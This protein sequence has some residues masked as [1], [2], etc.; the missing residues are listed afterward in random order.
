MIFLDMEDIDPQY[1]SYLIQDERRS[2]G[3]ISQ[4]LK[5]RYPCKKGLSER[6]VRRFCKEYGITNRSCIDNKSLDKLVHDTV[7]K[8]RY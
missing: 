4:I 7:K 5:R 6:S 1:I 8:V 3:D 2:H